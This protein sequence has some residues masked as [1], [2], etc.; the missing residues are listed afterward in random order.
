M[1]FVLY[2]INV[3]CRCDASMLHESADNTDDIMLFSSENTKLFK[4]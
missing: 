3:E 4:K 1:S 2:I